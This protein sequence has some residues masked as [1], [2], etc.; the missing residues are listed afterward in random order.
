MPYTLSD[1]RNLHITDKISSI[2]N[3]TKDSSEV[4]V[5]TELLKIDTNKSNEEFL[6]TFRELKRRHPFINDLCRRS[7]FIGYFFRGNDYRAERY[8]IIINQLKHGSYETQDH[9]SVPYFPTKGTFK[10]SVCEKVEDIKNEYLK[11]TYTSKEDLSYKTDHKIFNELSTFNN[12]LEFEPSEKAMSTDVKPTWENFLKTNPEYLCIREDNQHSEMVNINGKPV[13]SL[14]REALEMLHL[15]NASK[16]LTADNELNPDLIE[17]RNKAVKR[18]QNFTNDVTMKRNL[19]KESIGGKSPS[20][21]ISRERKQS[22]SE[23][24]HLV[25]TLELGNGGNNAEQ[26]DLN[27]SVQFKSKSTLQEKETYGSTQKYA[28]YSH[29]SN[30]VSLDAKNSI[31]Q[32]HSTEH[33]TGDLPLVKTPST[34]QADNNTALDKTIIDSAKKPGRDKYMVLNEIKKNMNPLANNKVT[35]AHSKLDDCAILFIETANLY[36]GEMSKKKDNDIE[37]PNIVEEEKPG[38]DIRFEQSKDEYVD[39]QDSGPPYTEL[40][41][42]RYYYQGNLIDDTYIEQEY[43]NRLAHILDVEA[44][45]QKLN[46]QASKKITPGVNVCDSHGTSYQIDLAKVVSHFNQ[47]PTTDFVSLQNDSKISITLENKHNNNVP[48]QNENKCR[49]VFCINDIPIGAYNIEQKTLD[50]GET[51]YLLIPSKLKQRFMDEYDNNSSI[52][53]TLPQGGQKI[54]YMKDIQFNNYKISKTRMLM[55][56]KKSDLGGHLSNQRL[57]DT[58]E[59][60][61]FMKYKYVND[62]ISVPKKIKLKGGKDFLQDERFILP[63]TDGN[64]TRMTVS[65]IQK[66]TANKFDG[67]ALH[68]NTIDLSTPEK[69]KSTIHDIQM[70][71]NATFELNLGAKAKFDGKTENLSNTGFNEI[72]NDL[73]SEL[74]EKD[75][76]Y[77]VGTPDYMTPA[78]FDR[79]FQ[80]S[81]NKEDLVLKALLIDSPKPISILENI[82]LKYNNVSNSNN[83]EHSEIRKAGEAVLLII[84]RDLR[85]QDDSH[86]KIYLKKKEA[87]STIDLTVRSLKTSLHDY[88]NALSRYY[89]NQNNDNDHYEQEIRIL[90]NLLNKEADLLIPSFKLWNSAQPDSTSE[91]LKNS[92]FDAVD[93]LAHP[94]IKK[95]MIEIKNQR[96]EI[97]KTREN[98]SRNLN[99]LSNESNNNTMKKSDVRSQINNESKDNDEQIKDTLIWLFNSLFVQ[100]SG[101]PHDDLTANKSMQIDAIIINFNTRFVK[102]YKKTICDQTVTI[103]QRTKLSYLM[104]KLIKKYQT[105]DNMPQASKNLYDNLETFLVP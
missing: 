51:D 34:M 47:I 35:G 3:S 17:K 16:L 97:I 21:L 39:N 55:L 27:Q 32:S 44:R 10:R 15:P 69:V 4:N 30:S 23:S 105:K 70:S 88:F 58:I 87:A 80:R 60:S 96:R 92:L 42:D 67:D 24:E 62:D 104:N 41:N 79:E 91:S 36:N 99:L 19:V 83:S 94:D 101:T 2:N 25:T 95:K 89:N 5:L 75:P 73:I 78:I 68:H 22:R 37:N 72:D 103:I 14:T 53:N 9:N 84:N 28:Q 76:I 77:A 56:Y 71:S 20:V 29:Q 102:L 7:S 63:N 85:C 43:Q 98:E 50:G 18:I 81:T 54:R 59:K 57:K 82:F 31:Q 26:E 64:Q 52:I 66:A 93:K 61:Q 100:Q 49:Y 48:T 13:L 8:K 45:N 90:E 33:F 65:K 74:N 1:S 46:L 38:G 6:Q 11:K 86:Q 12:N 40:Q